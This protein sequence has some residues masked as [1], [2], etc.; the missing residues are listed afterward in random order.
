MLAKL[1]RQLGHRTDLA[2]AQIASAVQALTDDAVPAIDKADF[3]TALALKGETPE[4]IFAFVAELR[5]RAVPVSVPAEVR[6]HGVL[7][8]V[9]TGGDR[10]GTINLSSAAA[11][12]AAAA[13][14]AV[15]KHGNRA[16]T[17]KSGSADVLQ[18]LGLPT[19]L[20]AAAAAA[21]L[22]ERG[23]VFLF[24]PLYHPAF[25]AIAPARKLCADRGQRTLF[26]LLGP[27]LNPARPDFQLMG[28]PSPEWCEPLARVL[29][30]L[31]VLRG[32]VVCGEAG[33]R[34]GGQ[35]I[36][37]DEISSLGETTLASFHEGNPVQVSRLSPKEFPLQ[38]ARVEDLLGG[39]SAVNAAILRAILTGEDRGPKR[40]AVLLNA[41]GAL[42]VAGRAA[43]FYDGWVEA[44]TLVD[45]GTVAR[46]LAALTA[47]WP[48]TP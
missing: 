29:Q 25:R 30:L 45:N 46:K 26:N 24:A 42:F 18:A 34:A 6:A 40:D 14:V 22:R 33:V 5:A 20:P 10:L 4:E 27:L 2:P 37:L 16:V 21:M 17:S 9:G 44:E 15:A 7:D 43:S 23:F 3:L 47:P 39:D 12:V 41:A 38:A 36:H 13:G 1:T 11:I 35:P 31:G 28:V 32:M 19:D 48:G 8:V